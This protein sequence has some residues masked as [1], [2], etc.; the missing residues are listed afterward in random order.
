MCG[1][2]ILDTANKCP[3]CGHKMMTLKEFEA[4]QPQRK[5]TNKKGFTILRTL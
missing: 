5:T 2:P 1:N 3:F 4:F